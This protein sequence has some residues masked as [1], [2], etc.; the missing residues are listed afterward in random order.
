MRILFIIAHI[1]KGGGQAIQACRIIR[2]IAE[3][4]HN[5]KLLT[6]KTKEKLVKEPC[7]TQY[8]GELTFP[9][10]IISLKKEIRKCEGDYDVFQCFDYEYS[11]PAM[12]FS[13]IR[14]Y[15][16]RLG[17]NPYK[18]FKQRRFYFYYPI[19]KYYLPKTLRQAEKVIVNS[20]TLKEDF[21]NFQPVHI[22]NGYDPTFF[23]IE[24]Y[25]INVRSELK[26][27]NNKKILIYT[28][29]VI[30]RKNLEIIFNILG[31]FKNIHFLIV[32]N[33]NE[34]HYGDK[35]YKYLSGKYSDVKSRFT[36]VGEKKPEQ[37]VKY[38]FASDIFIFP[39]ILEGSPNSVLEAM[40]CKLP[41]ICS[42]IREHKAF[43]KHGENGFIFSNETDLKGILNT[44]L[45]DT[46]TCE[47][48][49]QKGY[50]YALEYHD[51]NI[52]TDKYIE[53]YKRNSVKDHS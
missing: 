46:H 14:P 22:P 47:K 23:N 51:I 32:G 49:S 48:V 40:L 31:D 43:I 35:Y 12:Y 27:P 17:M 8:C 6:L 41:V 34:E 53:L 18:E 39:S 5:C 2:G 16:I 20:E 30:F 52:A 1:G 25:K 24:N 4:G 50:N 3:K 26:I 15:Y 19:L 13:K 10:G 29:K 9:S 33:I 37:V 44:L 28:G 21:I 45:S 36:F 11:L 38:L 42:E 7:N